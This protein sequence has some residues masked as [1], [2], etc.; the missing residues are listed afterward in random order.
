MPSSDIAMELS[1]AVGDA[2]DESNEAAKKA[3][4][5][6][7]RHAQLLA[8]RNKMGIGDAPRCNAKTF[9]IARTLF[10]RLYLLLSTVTFPFTFTL[11]FGWLPRTF[12]LDLDVLGIYFGV[13]LTPIAKYLLMIVGGLV[14]YYTVIGYVKSLDPTMD[15]DRAREKTAV[16]KEKE[17]QGLSSS[18]ISKQL[19]ME[20]VKTR[21]GRCQRRLVRFL[22][23]ALDSLY[24]PVATYVFQM[25]LLSP[26]VHG[27]EYR[28]LD[29]GLARG[30]TFRCIPCVWEYPYYNNIT[31][32]NGSLVLGCGYFTQC[33]GGSNVD[34]PRIAEYQKFGP[35]AFVS[36]AGQGH[37][38][39]KQAILV[40]Q[41][42][43]NEYGAGA[44]WWVIWGGSLA[45]FLF[46]LGLLTVTFQKMIDVAAPEVSED[47]SDHD[48]DAVIKEEARYDPY[49]FLFEGYNVDN[50]MFK[51]NTMLINLLQSF[52]VT[53]AMMSGQEVFAA[54][55]A[56]IFL[57]FHGWRVTGGKQG[58]FMPPYDSETEGLANQLDRFWDVIYSSAC[59]SCSGRKKRPFHFVYTSLAD[60]INEWV[61]GRVA[62]WMITAE[63]CF[64][65][66]QYFD[67][68]NIDVV[69]GMLMN[70]IVGAY[71]VVVIAIM[72]WPRTPVKVLV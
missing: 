68:P 31:G 71:G 63:F 26:N 49:V 28:C 17:K 61:A 51:I 50:K 30:K 59:C 11:A 37:C 48:Y 67:V 36:A 46:F 14:V 65:A 2:A 66:L 18:Q 40:S 47:I 70:V 39:S 56:L 52:V 34:K 35:Q 24:F 8:T 55:V 25:I 13:E 72:A 54:F 43:M 41:S 45:C 33:S 16:E 42:I 60:R 32:T 69:F 19:W 1:S 44:M 12:T 20:R 53:A 38:D 29:D 64:L 5:K 6:A 62:I 27:D 4:K 23:L 3:A 15:I 7:A 22:L 58:D 57:F 10:Q 21:K 9:E